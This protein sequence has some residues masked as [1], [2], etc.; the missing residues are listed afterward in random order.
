MTDMNGVILKADRRG[1]LRHTPVQKRKLVEAYEA[2]GL[3]CP[4]FAA[5][6]GGNY[7]T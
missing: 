2:S 3:S 7:Q 5:P 4:R 6:H 1:C